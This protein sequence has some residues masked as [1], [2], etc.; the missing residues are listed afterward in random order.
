MC[1]TC[2]HLIEEIGHQIFEKC[3]CIASA[4]L[5]SENRMKKVLGE[6]RQ[7]ISRG[8]VNKNKVRILRVRIN[9]YAMTQNSVVIKLTEAENSLW[10]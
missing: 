7:N 10:D 9:S 8:A 5:T 4:H 6:P 2:A 1:Q 3:P